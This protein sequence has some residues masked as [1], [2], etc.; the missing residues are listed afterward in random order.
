MQ[1][2]WQLGRC[3]FRLCCS[4]P[5]IPI[6]GFPTVSGVCGVALSEQCGQCVNSFSFRFKPHCCSNRNPTFKTLMRKK[7][8]SHLLQFVPFFHDIYQP[9]CSIYILHAGQRTST[10]NLYTCTYK[11]YLTCMGKFKITLQFTPKKNINK[12]EIPKN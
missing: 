8:T 9:L 2:H 4:P 3:D 10:N 12:L 1:Q 11:H 5:Q 6:L 7:H